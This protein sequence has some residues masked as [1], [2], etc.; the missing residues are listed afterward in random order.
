MTG[1]FMVMA[2]CAVLLTISIL[3]RL[4]GREGAW[5]LRLRSGDHPLRP[6]VVDGPHA[7]RCCSAVRAGV[8]SDES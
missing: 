1:L 3:F 6:V 2:L 4:G 5:G 7:G 8:V